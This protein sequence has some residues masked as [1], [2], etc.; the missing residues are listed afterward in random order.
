MLKG[1]TVNRVD[2]AH[3]SSSCV[4]FAIKKICLSACRWELPSAL[5]VRP[6]QNSDRDYRKPGVR[7]LEFFHAH[8]GAVLHLSAL[9]NNQV[10][11]ACSCGLVCVQ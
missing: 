10:V 3:Y 11:R 8:V 1:C 4:S 7:P 6:T 9:G 5:P 2:S